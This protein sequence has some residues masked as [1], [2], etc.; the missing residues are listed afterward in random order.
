[1]NHKLKSLTNVNNN[2]VSLQYNALSVV[3]DN[4]LFECKMKEGG[5]VKDHN[6]R[7]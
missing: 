7:I 6:I 5:G 2:Q 1:M 3:L 4:V